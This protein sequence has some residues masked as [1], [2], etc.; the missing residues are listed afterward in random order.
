MSPVMQQK[1]TIE[2]LR[3]GQVDI[4]VGTHRL[5]S[6]DVEFKDLGLL[7]VDEEQRFGQLSR[8]IGHLYYS[9]SS[10]MD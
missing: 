6:K 1:H 4:V 3:K 8:H 10:G 7:I 5:L 9:P 2:D